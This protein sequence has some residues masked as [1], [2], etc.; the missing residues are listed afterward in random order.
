MCLFKREQISKGTDV[1]ETRNSAADEGVTHIWRRGNL[2]E[3]LKV[4][5]LI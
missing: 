1:L 4:L 5:D 2:R 3:A